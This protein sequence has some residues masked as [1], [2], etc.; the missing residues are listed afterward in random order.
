MVRRQLDFLTLPESPEH[1]GGDPQGP[2]ARSLQV[3]WHGEGEGHYRRS[4]PHRSRLAGTREPVVVDQTSQYG[5]TRIAY[6]V[7]FVPAKRQRIAIHVHPDG[8]VQVDATGRTSLAEI[9]AAVSRRARWLAAQLDRIHRQRTHLLPREYVSG[10]SHLNLGRRYLLKVHESTHETPA[11]NCAADSSKS[12]PT[13]PIERESKPCFGTGI[14][15]T[16]VL[17]SINGWTIS[18]RS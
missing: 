14:G 16:P 2:G 1:R 7:F 10:E 9:K 18:A 5:D 13:V 17:C 11:S 12:L 4:N 8:R 3:G 15:S 6:R